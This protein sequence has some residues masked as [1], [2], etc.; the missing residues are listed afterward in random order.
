MKYAFIYRTDVGTTREVNQDSLVIRSL[1]F[2]D[3]DSLL[4]AV[5]DGLGGLAEGE[6]ISREAAMMASEWFDTEF[7]PLVREGADAANVSLRLKT[8]LEN[9]NSSLFFFNQQRGICGGTTM[10]LLL[11]WDGY[12]F[13]AHVG[14]SRIY[15]IQEKGMNQLTPDHSWV[16]RQVELG[17]MTQEEALHSGQKNIILQCLG[18]ERQLANP[19]LHYEKAPEDRGYLLCTDGF[20]HQM[21][22][23]RLLAHF[24]PSVFDR[25]GADQELGAEVEA[26]KDKGEQDNITAV[27]AVAQGHEYG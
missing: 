26:I 12:R 1:S 3:S 7:A 10:S 13:I 5:C 20:W 25:A 22:S 17:K 2:D 8:F 27:V 11:L 16:A 14:D 21:D 24:I 15:E 6:K 4:L 23:A 9:T 18:T 19:Y